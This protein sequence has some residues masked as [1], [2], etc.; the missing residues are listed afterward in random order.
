[1]NPKQLVEAFIRL[2]VQKEKNAEALRP[3]LCDAF[4]YQSPMSEFRSAE[5]FLAQPWEERLQPRS[6]EIES[7]LGDDGKA[8]VAYEMDAVDPDTGRMSFTDWFTFEGG[9]ILAVKSTFD[10]AK[11]KEHAF[12]I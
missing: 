1:M 4:R 8:C 9:K 10:A 11:L 6:I 2:S 7:F 12:R 5:H 3:L